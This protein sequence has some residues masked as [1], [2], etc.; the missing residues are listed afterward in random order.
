MSGDARSF[1]IWLYRRFE[2]LKHRNIIED[3]NKI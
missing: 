3:K 2:E 1:G